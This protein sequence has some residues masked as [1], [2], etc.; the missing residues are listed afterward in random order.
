MTEKRLSD[1]EILE[2]LSANPELR[3]RIGSLL[4]AIEDEQGDLRE[5]DAAELRMIEEMRQMGR[6]SLTAWAQRQ[7]R[8]TSQEVKEAEGV[9]REGKKNCTGTP[10]SAK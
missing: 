3:E 4:L 10:P 6:E 5:A 9:W 8:K 2:K 1:A 7:V